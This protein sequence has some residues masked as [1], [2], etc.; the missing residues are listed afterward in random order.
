M[1]CS[2]DPSHMNGHYDL[3]CSLAS[4]L[5]CLIVYVCGYCHEIRWHSLLEMQRLVQ[6]LPM[7][8]CWLLRISWPSAPGQGDGRQ[9]V[10][11][12]SWVRCD[13]VRACQHGLPCVEMVMRF[14]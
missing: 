9:H 13:C 14:G 11:S 10:T 4:G 7:K 6:H 12:F 8:G 5:A 2:L 3:L 1:D